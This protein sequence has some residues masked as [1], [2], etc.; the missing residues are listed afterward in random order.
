MRTRSVDPREPL[1]RAIAAYKAA[2]RVTH[3]TRSCVESDSPT[4]RA[5]TLVSHSAEG[6]GNLWFRSQAFVRARALF[7][8]SSLSS[9]IIFGKLSLSLPHLPFVSFLPSAE[10]KRRSQLVAGGSRVAPATKAYKRAHTAERTRAGGLFSSPPHAA[11]KR[12]KDKQPL[13]IQGHSLT[14]WNLPTRG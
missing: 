12:R 10:A 6:K 8:L 9:K 1:S 11:R 3:N 14:I 2:W 4:A 7:F 5:S 13:P